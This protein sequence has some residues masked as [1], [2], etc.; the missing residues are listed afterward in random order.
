MS[1][2]PR[3]RRHPGRLRALGSFRLAVADAA[4]LSALLVPM[5]VKAGHDKARSGGLIAAS[6]IIGPVIPPSIGF[7]IFGVA[8]GVS[9]SKLFLAELP[10]PDA[11][12]RPCHR[13]VD[14]GAQGEPG[15]TAT[16]HRAG[17]A[18]RSSTAPGRWACHSSSFGLKFGI[19]TTEAAVVAAVYS[20]FVAT[21]IYR[22]LKL[23]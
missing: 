19:F 13:L 10:R 23:L 12:S 3:L 14:R 20:L 5:M 17:A 1:G 8:G 4:A 2:R 18:A 21:C 6:G 16:G 9:I 15:H 11:G 7:V 22:E